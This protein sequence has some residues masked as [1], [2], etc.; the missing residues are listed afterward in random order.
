MSSS[1]LK[2]LLLTMKISEFLKWGVISYRLRKSKLLLS[3]FAL[4]TYHGLCTR[5]VCEDGLQIPRDGSRVVFAETC[6][7]S[8][9]WILKSLDRSAAEISWPWNLP[10]VV[11]VNRASANQPDIW[12]IESCKG[13]RVSLN[14]ASPVKREWIH[15]WERKFSS[16]SQ[17]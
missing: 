17:F 14:L 11:D 1:V 10:Q 4:P 5:R 12:H 2:C 8:V 16:V 7:N 6:V 9:V 15:S 13:Y 3:S